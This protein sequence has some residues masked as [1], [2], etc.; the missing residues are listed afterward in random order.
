MMVRVKQHAEDRTLNDISRFL[1]DIDRFFT[2]DHWIV[3]DLEITG[4]NALAIE[5]RCG[6]GTRLS[7]TEFR[8][9]YNGIF[10]TIWGR[11]GI[12]SQGDLVVQI[13]AIDS[14]YWEVQSSDAEFEAHMVQRYGEYGP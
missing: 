7:D 3:A 14:S 13:D 11:F 8:T 5:E 9:M 6:S 1:V 4:D 2:P 10:Q 12:E